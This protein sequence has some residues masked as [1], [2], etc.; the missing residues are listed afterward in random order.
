[1]VVGPK[2]RRSAGHRD[3]VRTTSEPLPNEVP[4]LDH[5]GSAKS[6]RS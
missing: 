1:M 5:L 6:R 4:A 2:V 3:L